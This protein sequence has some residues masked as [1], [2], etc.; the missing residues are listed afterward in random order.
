MKYITSPL[1]S[2][3]I[4]T[5]FSC[6]KESLDNYLH[7]QVNQD[8]KKKITTC[9]VLADGKNN[10]V[11]YYTLSS[12]TIPRDQLPEKIIKKLPKSYLNLPTTLLGRLALDT[13]HKGQGMGVLLLL[14]A[15][16]RS[17]DVANQSIGSM[18]VTVNP[19]DNEATKFY[20][21]Y[22]FVL[23][24]DGGKMFIHMNSIKLVLN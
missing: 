1:S 23:M 14:D 12:D 15:L 18:A 16:R 2:S 22:G 6:G 21:K 20:E 7:K 5:K 4:R 24:P 8:I 19:L 13:N 10:V 17:M 9:F 11:G 3:H